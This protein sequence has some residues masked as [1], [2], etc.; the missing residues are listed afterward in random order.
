[1]KTCDAMVD[2]PVACS[3]RELD[4]TYPN[5]RFVLTVRDFDSWLYSTERHLSGRIPD[6]QWKR[7]VRLKTYGVLR[8][9]RDAFTNAYYSH[10][11]AVIDHFKR[12]SNALLTINIVA[13]QGWD[14]LC[15]FLEVPIPTDRFPFAKD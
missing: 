3:F 13:G 4:V 2:T 7:E 11:Q 15:P 14:L 10:T 6:E 9:N 5:S 8:W 12:R 1:M